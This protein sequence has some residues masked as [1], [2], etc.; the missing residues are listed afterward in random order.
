MGIR[1]FFLYIGSSHVEWPRKWLKDE[2]NLH[3]FKSALSL[4]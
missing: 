4:S 1:Y 2:I 3:S